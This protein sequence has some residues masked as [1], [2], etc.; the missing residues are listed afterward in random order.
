MAV[1]IGPSVTVC[2]IVLW[3]VHRMWKAARA[4]VS[5]LIRAS[6]M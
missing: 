4:T 6:V 1:V 3:L 5:R 2:R